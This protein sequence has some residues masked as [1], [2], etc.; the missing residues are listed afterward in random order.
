MYF[1]QARYYDYEVGRFNRIDP[2]RDGENFYVYVGNNPVN[3]VDRDGQIAFAALIPYLVKASIGAVSDIL[4]QLLVGTIGNL[5]NGETSV[6]NAMV[7][8]FYEINLW[9]AG[10]SAI[11]SM[12][13]FQ[14]KLVK[15]SVE[16]AT[17]T[18]ANII[19]GDITTVQDALIDFGIGFLASGAGE[20]IEKYGK[21]VVRD[22]FVK[23]GIDE[24]K[25]N[26]VL[27]L[28]DV[29]KVIS[30]RVFKTGKEAEE[31]LFDILGGETQ[32][33]FDT[34]LGK[35]F[36]DVFVDN[37]AHE[38]KV[39]YVSLTEFVKKQIRKRCVCKRC[40]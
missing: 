22:A 19:S 31:Y 27:G 13:G 18:A 10:A 15:A 17:G 9:Q 38:S 4:G 37:V 40:S 25:V 16:A 35:R 23:L 14:S 24:A 20:L 7:N 21:P 32:K 11:T 6:W 2:I 36:V 33:R 39:G 1:A 26:N 5:I 30:K 12:F 34:V 8:A 29:V 3:Y 28:D